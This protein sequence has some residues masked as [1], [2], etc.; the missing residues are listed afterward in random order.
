MV[1]L[2]HYL[3]AQ[4]NPQKVCRIDYDFVPCSWSH[5]VGIEFMRRSRMAN[6]QKEIS[7]DCLLASGPGESCL[8]INYFT[9]V[10]AKVCACLGITLV[11]DGID[12]L[13]EIQMVCYFLD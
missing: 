13:C 3:F 5:S 1:F 10:V 4:L 6:R 7:K 11:H 8:F 9:E 2:L 12:F